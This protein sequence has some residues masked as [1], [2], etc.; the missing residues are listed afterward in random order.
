MLDADSTGEK[1]MGEPWKGKATYICHRWTQNLDSQP[2]KDGQLMPGPVQTRS[3]RWFTSLLP[4]D[5][6]GHHLQM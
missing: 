2:L 1:G 4:H 6:H 5:S 3:Y